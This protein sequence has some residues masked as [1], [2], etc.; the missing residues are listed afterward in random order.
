MLTALDSNVLI[1]VIVDDPHFANGSEAALREASLTGSLIISECVLAELVPVLPQPQLTQ[2]LADWNI[3]FS[4]S[5]QESALLAGNMF[6]RYFERRKPR[7]AV[8]VVA[9]FLIGAH[10]L[11]GADRLLTRDRGFYRDYFT[12]LEVMTP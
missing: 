1:D 7:E 4:A 10:A 6:A 12:S 5:T 9:D 11:N 3:Q 8:R 2:L